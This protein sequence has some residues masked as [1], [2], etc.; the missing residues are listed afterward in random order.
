[1]SNI[2]RTL[3]ITSFLFGMILMFCYIGWHLGY[4]GFIIVGDITM[5][6]ALIF[7][8]Q[9]VLFVVNL[10]LQGG[11]VLRE[12]TWKILYFS[13]PVAVIEAGRAIFLPSVPNIVFSGI[14]P[15]VIYIIAAIRRKSLKRTLISIA[16]VNVAILAHQFVVSCI[17]QT[18]LTCDVSI[19][20]VLRLSVDSIL[21][22][23]LFYSIGGV[24]RELE[25]LVFP[26][27]TRDERNCDVGRESDS[28]DS[29]SVPVDK[30]EK[31][32]MRSV[33][34]VVQVIQ[35]MFIL[36]VCSLDNLFLDAL[37]MT[38]SFICH[39]TIINKRR[40]LK[41]VVL[42]TL[43]ATAMFYFAARFTVSFT[44]S[45]FFPIFIGLLLTYTVYRVSYQFDKVAEERAEK[46]L[47]RIKALEMEIEDAWAR[48]EELS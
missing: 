10:S 36:W 7:L 17:T 24:K 27:R 46:D 14:L 37:V 31:L 38:T 20:T 13:L 28:T 48:L 1:M 39:G 41:P 42:C 32:V 43:V 33:I 21:L 8:I 35:W 45:Q 26:G 19:Y 25:F 16:M 2:R 15:I 29:R 4:E 3:Q 44:Y 47:Q 6:P 22:M 5:P 18:P 11:F 34:A 9:F 40:H 12:Y 23:L 30:F